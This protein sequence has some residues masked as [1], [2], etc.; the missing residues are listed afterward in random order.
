MLG[1]SKL[2]GGFVV[3][4][5]A[6]FIARDLMLENASI[7]RPFA[8]GFL[9]LAYGTFEKGRESFAHTFE[10]IEDLLAEV[11]AERRVKSQD[12]SSRKT[13]EKGSAVKVDAKEKV[14]SAQKA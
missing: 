7:F 2:G 1:K 10:A 13:A 14:K 3:G 12:D 9:K 5:G 11:Q 8:K 6:G 4:F